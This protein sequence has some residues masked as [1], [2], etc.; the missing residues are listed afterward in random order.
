MAE[1]LP[2]TEEEMLARLEEAF[3][4]DR[5]NHLSWIFMEKL[6]DPAARPD[7]KYRQY[8]RPILFITG[9]LA[10]ITLGT[11]LYFSSQT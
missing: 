4:Q 2:L 9:L 11:F 7:G 1:L 3:R 8:I 5:E 6:K 10:L